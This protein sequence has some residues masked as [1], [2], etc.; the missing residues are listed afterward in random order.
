MLKL[1]DIKIGAEIEGLI[2]NELAKI[3]AINPVGNN[4]I[5]VYYKNHSGEVKEQLL[6]RD[7]EPNLSLAKSGLAWSFD[8]P[9]RDFKLALE[10]LR[11]Q[12]G[13]LFDPMMAIHSSNVEPLPHQISAVYESML[14]KQPLRFVLADDPGAGKTIMAG[15]LIKELL[16]RADAQRVLI[17]APGSLTEQWQDEMRDKFTIDFKLFSREQ[18]ELSPS[19][20]YFDDEN[21]LIARIDQLARAEDLQQKLRATRWDLIIVDEAHK[22]SAHRFGNKVNK[23]QRYLLGE[24]MTSWHAIVTA[25]ME[26]MKERPQQMEL[27]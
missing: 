23:T 21:L 22:L 3:V 6:F 11:I 18:Q 16:M 12:M 17:V 5:T 14:P 24:L 25:S 27:F 15:L 8:S 1:E 9:S 7:S 10:A 19:G 20:N 13:F 26:Y 4:A 2:P